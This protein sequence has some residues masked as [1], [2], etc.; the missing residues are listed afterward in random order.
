V[1]WHCEDMKR[2]DETSVALGHRR[3]AITSVRKEARDWAA[4]NELMRSMDGNTDFVPYGA[5]ENGRASA[6][7]CPTS[8]GRGA[9]GEQ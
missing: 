2:T 4:I 7:L 6:T 9:G 3:K 5:Y 1:L 8:T